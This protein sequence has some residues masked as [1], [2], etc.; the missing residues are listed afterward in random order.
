VSLYP[1]FLRL[2]GRLAVVVGGGTVGRR[3]ARGL[4]DAGGRVR[5]VCREPRPAEETSP[6]LEW[7]C[8]SYRAEHLD[9]AELVF[10]AATPDVNRRVVEDA[11]AR[12]VWVC[13]ATEP[14]DG[15]FQTASTIRRGDLTVAL[16]TGGAAPALTRALRRRMEAML[17]EQLSEWLTLLAELRPIILARIS[18]PER[19]RQLWERLCDESW[20][21]RL[22]SEG[23]ERVR[24]AMAGTVDHFAAS[25]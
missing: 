25:V 19:R 22:R 17:D 9:G 18:D 16:G 23:G 7:L 24:A 21:D 15:D 4:L 6:N 20:L 10:A 12:G 2:D 13:S 14:E 1:L 11:R 5:L 3:K 8:E